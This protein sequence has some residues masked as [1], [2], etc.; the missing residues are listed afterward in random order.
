[1]GAYRNQVIGIVR[2]EPGIPVSLVVSR[3]IQLHDRAQDESF[4]RFAYI[5]VAEA[6]GAGDI[7]KVTEG[8]RVRLYPGQTSNGA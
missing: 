8:P 4:R 6:I 1:M 3:F 7:T 5:E 2:A